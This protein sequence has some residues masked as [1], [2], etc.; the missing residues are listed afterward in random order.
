[1]LIPL[2]VLRKKKKTTTL[3][4]NIL[5]TAFCLKYLLILLVWSLE[6]VGGNVSNL[7]YWL[8]PV[9]SLRRLF[10]FFFLIINQ[11][12]SCVFP[13]FFFPG[14]NTTPRLC[15]CIKMFKLNKSIAIL[16]RY[17]LSL[18]INGCMILVNVH[19]NA[20]VTLFA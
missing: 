3:K 2:T 14:K 1:M 5:F 19:R 16:W 11:F 10:F 12:P 4:V 17:C 7:N 8:F 13:Y 18:T 9:L 15:L 20:L 6:K